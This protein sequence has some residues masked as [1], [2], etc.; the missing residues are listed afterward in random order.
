MG[1]F[2]VL[3]NKIFK[4]LNGK[5]LVFER[6]P[7]SKLCKDGELRAYM[8][9]GYWKCMDNLSEKNQLEEIYKKK[10]LYGK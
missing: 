7:L 4:Y 1:G 10:K 9:N 8:H 6:K 2:F 3:N 5:N